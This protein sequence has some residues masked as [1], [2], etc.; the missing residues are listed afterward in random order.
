VRPTFPSTGPC[1]HVP[2]RVRYLV[3]ATEKALGA[4]R[5][6]PEAPPGPRHPAEEGL[7]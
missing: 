4:N 2:T 6:G 5:A 1:W 3:A 7:R